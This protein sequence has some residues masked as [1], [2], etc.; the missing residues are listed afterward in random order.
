MMIDKSTKH[1][2]YCGSYRFLTVNDVY[3]FKPDRYGKRTHI[4]GAT[5]LFG[6]RKYLI[7]EQEQ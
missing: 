3:A 6:N 1:R 5:F 4:F 7:F 2:K